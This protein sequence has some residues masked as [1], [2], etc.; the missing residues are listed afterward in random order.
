[1]KIGRK[2]FN[3][4]N[5]NICGKDNGNAFKIGSFKK[6]SQL[7]FSLRV[8]SLEILRFPI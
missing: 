8:F 5:A 3:S 1:M 6:K 7:A 4:S 2:Y